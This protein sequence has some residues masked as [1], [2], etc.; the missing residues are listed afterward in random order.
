MEIY[1]NN[2]VVYNIISKIFS[3]VDFLNSGTIDIL[4]WILVCY[5]GLSHAC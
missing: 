5:G 4:G 1:F 3:K 2:V